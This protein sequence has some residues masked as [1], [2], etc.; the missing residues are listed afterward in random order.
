MKGD[1]LISGA[2]LVSA[3]SSITVLTLIAVFMFKEGAPIFAKTGLFGMFGQEWDPLHQKFGILPFIV[4]SI[5]ITFGALVIGVPTGVLAAT[6]L[7]VFAKKK[8]SAVLKPV[9]ELLAGIPSVVYGFIGVIWLAPIIRTR[10]GGAGLSI[11]AA[12]IVLAI[13]ILPTIIGVSMDAINAVPKSFREGS[14]ALGATEWQTAW[15]VTLPAARSGILISIILGMGRAIGETMAVIMIAG[16]STI[17]PKSILDP[18]RTLTANI[19]IEM[20]YAV[21]DHR[22]A[23]FATAI[24]LFLFIVILNSIALK[25]SRRKF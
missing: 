23:L 2:L 3:F 12:S 21:G 1:R 6:Y 22:R 4:G 14:L 24:I 18:A 5:W 20:G 13:M 10:L 7:A 25:L 8:V 11:L 19:A 16:N 15:R 17:I 9:I